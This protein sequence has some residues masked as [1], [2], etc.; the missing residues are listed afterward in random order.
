MRVKVAR[1]HA[2]NFYDVSNALPANAAQTRQCLACNEVHPV[3]YCRLKRTGFENCGLCG[4][5]HYGTARTC[6]NLQSETQVRLMLDAL[7]TSTDTKD[8]IDKARA[9]LRGVVGDLVRRKKVA[10]QVMMQQQ[11]QQHQ[12]QQQI[13][14]MQP[15]PEAQVISSDGA[16]NGEA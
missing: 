12:H 8:N 2:N 9:Y 15:R 14:Q 5:A 16:Q 11:M 4:L 6:P 10:R 1:N 3:G 7:K 13:Q